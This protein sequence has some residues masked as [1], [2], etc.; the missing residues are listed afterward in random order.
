M[1]E[2][3]EEI[4][5]LGNTA[6]IK[7]I[8]EETVQTEATFETEPKTEIYGG[9]SPLENTQP[10]PVAEVKEAYGGASVTPV[11]EGPMVISSTPEAEPAPTV[12]AAPVAETPAPE[13]PAAPAVEAPKTEEVETLEF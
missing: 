1:E 12:E 11:V 4:E 2:E 10:V 13:A 9:S 3:K 8:N 6:P 5:T 7:T